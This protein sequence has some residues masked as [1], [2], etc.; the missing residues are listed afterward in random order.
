[1]KLDNSDV[2]ARERN[3]TKQTIQQNKPGLGF[4]RQELNI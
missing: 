1:M 4:S 2:G 3:R